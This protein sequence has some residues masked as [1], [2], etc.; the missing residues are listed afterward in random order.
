MAIDTLAGKAQAY[1]REAVEGGA[2]LDFFSPIPDWAR[3]RLSTIGEQVAPSASL[4]S[5][6]VS[7]AELETEENF[8]LDYL[9]LNRSA[10]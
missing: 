7:Q 4:L 6:I 8:L 1:A 2:R 9:F 5:F 3:R 10:A